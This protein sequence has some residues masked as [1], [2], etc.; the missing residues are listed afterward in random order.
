[1]Q[2]ILTA[3]KYANALREG[4]FLGLKCRACGG[5]TV[6]P[7]KVCSECH[8]E[9]AEEVEL[10]RNGQVR[11]FTVI[12]TPAEGFTPPYIVGLIE[13]DEGPWVTANIIGCPPEKATLERLIGR[14]GRIDYQEVPADMFS[15]GPRIALTFTPADDA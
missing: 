13:L 11:S 3:D 1:M 6:P 14:R 10:S 5:Y 15:G 4:K 7:R 2:Y 9:D 8:S 12:Y